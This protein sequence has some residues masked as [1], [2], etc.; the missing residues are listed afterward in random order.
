M[1]YLYTCIINISR[2]D[3]QCTCFCG[4]E[5]E[6][7]VGV[8]KVYQMKDYNIYKSESLI[9]QKDGMFESIATLCSIIK[10]RCDA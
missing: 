5:C 7:D 4:L 1:L 6:D 2:N 8:R 3:Y 9:K 10:F